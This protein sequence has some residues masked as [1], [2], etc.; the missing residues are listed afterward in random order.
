[1]PVFLIASAAK[2]NKLLY[3]SFDVKLCFC[4]TIL[5]QLQDHVEYMGSS[6]RV[7]LVPSIRDANHDHVFPQVTFYFDLFSY[8]FIC[9]FEDRVN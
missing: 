8:N 1:M 2:R 4:P 3:L 5:L 9:L 7:L 6:T